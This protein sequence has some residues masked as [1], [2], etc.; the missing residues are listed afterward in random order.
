MISLCGF[1]EAWVVPSHFWALNEKEAL[2]GS[3]CVT[4]VL[5]WT[6]THHSVFGLAELHWQNCTG[7]TAVA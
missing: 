3:W 2:W 4:E 6:N 7:R 1:P 5:G